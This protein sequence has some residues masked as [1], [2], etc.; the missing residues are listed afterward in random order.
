MGRDGP[1]FPDAGE[2]LRK[3]MQSLAEGHFD[4]R[5]EG[6]A[7]VNALESIAWSLIGLLR[8]V[9]GADDREGLASDILER[10]DMVRAER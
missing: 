3:A 9:Q 5:H 4:N 6:G 7:Q 10:L 1:P 8:H 2:A